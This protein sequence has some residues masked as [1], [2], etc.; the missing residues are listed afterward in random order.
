[1]QPLPTETVAPRPSSGWL[2]GGL[3]VLDPQG[4][5]LSVNA[6]LAE[7]LEETAEGLI[8]REW[9]QVLTHRRPEWEAG[10]R[11]WIES[12]AEFRTQELAG[13]PDQPDGWIRLT[14]GRSPGGLFAHIESTVPPR[15]RLEE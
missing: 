4:R 3:A 10:I 15:P 9:S 8:G 2:T 12:E 7:W 13:H 14:G 6:A 11:A 1:M 5:I